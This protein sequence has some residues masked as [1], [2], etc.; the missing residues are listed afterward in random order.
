MRWRRL[1]IHSARHTVNLNLESSERSILSGFIPVC[2]PIAG[3]DT[4]RI[5]T[6]DLALILVLVG[7]LQTKQPFIVTVPAVK[8]LIARGES[9]VTR[10][11]SNILH[12]V[13]KILLLV[14]KFR[15]LFTENL[16]KEK[17]NNLELHDR[18]QPL[19]RQRS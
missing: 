8:C 16:P 10:S 1:M 2:S 11:S 15:D 14:R 19:A 5:L 3:A 9:V 17:R 18:K 13:Q 12:L 6:V 7:L 4:N